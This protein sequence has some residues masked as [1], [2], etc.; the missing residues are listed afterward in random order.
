MKKFEYST[1][2]ENDRFTP[3]LTELN[4]LGAEGWQ[5]VNVQ[6]GAGTIAVFLLMREQQEVADV[7]NS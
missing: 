3:N 1:Y 2:V 5:V 7:R 4:R 6:S